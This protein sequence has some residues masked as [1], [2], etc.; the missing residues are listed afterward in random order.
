MNKLHEIK[1]KL[2]QGWGNL[3][4]SKKIAYSLLTSVIIV[5]LISFFIRASSTKYDVLFSNMTPEDSGAIVAKLKEK[6]TQYKI[7]GSSI[8]VPKGE[9]DSLRMELMSEVKITE[10]SNGFELFDSG[11]MAPTD[12]ETKIMYQRALSGEI[13]RAI[14]SFPEIEG[15]KV[16][17]VLPENTAF[18]RETEPASASVVIKLKA[19]TKLDNA[20]VKAVV[21]LLTGAVENLPKENVSIVSDKFQLLTEGLYDE[22][23]DTITGSTDKQQVLKAQIEKNLEAKIMKVLEPIYKNGVKVSVN[24]ELDFDALKKNSVKYEPKGTIVSSHDVE[25]WNGGSSTGLSKSP[26]D[27]GVID[28]AAQNTS[29]TTAKDGNVVN[30]DSTKNY[31][32][33]KTE[34]ILVKAPGGIKRITTSVVLDGNLDENTRTSVNNLVAKAI[35]YSQERGDSISVEGLNFNSDSKK[36]AEKALLDIEN[37][38]KSAEKKALYA[39]IAYGALAI[40]LFIILLIAIRRSSKKK[41]TASGGIDM[42]I[43]DN[44]APKQQE[45]YPPIEFEDNNKKFHME[46]EVKKYASEKPEQ[47]AEIIKSWLTEDER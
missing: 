36:M 42:I 5:A 10:G 44:V 46:K 32:N 14:K 4:K 41:E 38:S 39:R 17:L 25:T 33:S 19:G 23:K 30:R 15:A 11:K 45:I 31:E 37:A 18:V 34:E 20:Q 7:K 43:G 6:K 12:T 16:N 22:E 21:A 47:V 1:N 29:P 40:I 35:G 24:S 2:S 26:V 9:L 27:D 8:L 28:N 13:E 3:S